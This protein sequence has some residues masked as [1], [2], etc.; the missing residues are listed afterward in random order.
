MKVYL[1]YWC[2]NEPW[3]DYNETVNAV[4]SSYGSAVKFIEKQG[5]KPRACKSKWEIERFGVRFD[6]EPDEWGDK[7]SMWVGE[8]EVSE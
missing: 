3:E 8:M 1:V 2:N 5:Y 7:Y 6:S 4:F